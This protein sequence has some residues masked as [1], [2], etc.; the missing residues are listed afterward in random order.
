MVFLFFLFSGL[1]KKHT[2]THTNMVGGVTASLVGQNSRSYCVGRPSI[3]GTWAD[4]EEP[5]GASDLRTHERLNSIV[6][7]FCNFRIH[8]KCGNKQTC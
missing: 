2:H 7:N 8:F 5:C 3:S 1:A 4:S 6:K